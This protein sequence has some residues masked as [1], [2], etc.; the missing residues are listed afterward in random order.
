LSVNG[1]LTS[2]ETDVASRT[3]VLVCQGRAVAHGR[4]AAGR[5]DDPTAIGLLRDDERRPVET[6]RGGVPPRRFADR[7]EFE[8]LRASAEVLVPRTV[9]IDDALLEA[10]NP[11]VVIVGAG[12]DGRA[13]RMPPRNRRGVRSRLPGITAQ[14]A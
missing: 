5:F 4:L 13:W 11:Q 3:V 2:V 10:S 12:V 1:M 14:Q 6:V 8:R 7:M 9:A